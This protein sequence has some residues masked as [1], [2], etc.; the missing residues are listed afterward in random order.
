M[1]FVD[2]LADPTRD[3]QS[4]LAN[5]AVLEAIQREKRLIFSAENCELLKINSKD[6]TCLNVNDRSMKQADVACYL[7][8][9]F[10]RQGNNSDLCK[11]RVTKAKGTI[12][13]LGSL[14]KGINRGN[15][16]I[17]SML[18]LYKTVLIPRLIYN[19]EARGQ[20]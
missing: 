11:E 7:D 16:Q 19:C 14:C 15:K 9:D 13:E 4:A 3:K 8:D 2:D 20:I 18:L 6:N 5:N 1:E 10:N 12:I 17:E